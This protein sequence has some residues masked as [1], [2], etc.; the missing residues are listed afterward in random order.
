MFNLLNIITNKLK[1]NYFP[2][3]CFSRR[4]FYAFARM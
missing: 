1:W 4:F 2:T 3:A